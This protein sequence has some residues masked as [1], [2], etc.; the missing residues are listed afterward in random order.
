MY[1]I[2]AQGFTIDQDILEICRNKLVEAGSEHVIDEMLKY[3]GGIGGPKGYNLG[4][5]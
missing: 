4:F 5:K 1:F 3:E 2:L